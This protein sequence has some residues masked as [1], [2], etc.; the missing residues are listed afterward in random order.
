MIEIYQKLFTCCVQPT[1]VHV[2]FISITD[3]GREH[4]QYL[5]GDGLCLLTLI[6]W[7]HKYETSLTLTVRA[8]SGSDSI[9]SSDIIILILHT[10]GLYGQIV[11]ITHV[12]MI[13]EDGKID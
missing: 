5:S 1:A 12:C 13:I 3:R 10:S 8:W 11:H 9:G 7:N 4:H 6:G 2:S